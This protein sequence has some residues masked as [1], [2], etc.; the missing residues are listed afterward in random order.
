MTR[1]NHEIHFAWRA[2]YLLKEVDNDFSRQ[3]QYLVKVDCDLSWQ[4]HDF[5]EFWEIAGGRHVAS[6]DQCR[7]EFLLAEASK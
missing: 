6:S 5:V 2:P 7:I 4:A 3:A 1:I